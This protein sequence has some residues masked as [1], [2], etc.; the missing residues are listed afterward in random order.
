M[1][2]LGQVVN[3]GKFIAIL[4]MVVGP[5]W[6]LIVGLEPIMI[7][8]SAGQASEISCCPRGNI[9]NTPAGFLTASM[10]SKHLQKSPLPNIKIFT[11]R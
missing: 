7:L 9:V 3:H 8:T 2:V 5:I 11:R 10:L 1:S 4:F 6:L